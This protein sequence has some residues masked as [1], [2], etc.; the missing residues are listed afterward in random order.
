MSLF[1]LNVEFT[2]ASPRHTFSWK[3]G[4]LILHRSSYFNRYSLRSASQFCVSLKMRYSPDTHKMLARQHQKKNQTTGRFINIM[5]A[6]GNI[7]INIYN[8]ACICFSAIYSWFLLLLFSF[9]LLCVISVR[10][11]NDFNDNTLFKPAR[12]FLSIEWENIFINDINIRFFVSCNQKNIFG[13]QNKQ[14][15]K[16]SWW[17]F[18]MRLLCSSLDSSIVQYLFA[19]L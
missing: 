13:T 3:P 19:Q 16:Q 15:S 12:A 9:K 4:M 7:T 11:R 5:A 10:A 17:W 18:F 14:F 1:N 6:I 2:F 8:I